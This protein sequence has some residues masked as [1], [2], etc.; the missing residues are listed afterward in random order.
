MLPEFSPNL[1]ISR[2][3][4]RFTMP[5]AKAQRSLSKFEEMRE[6]L[7]DPILRPEAQAWA[8]RHG[9]ELIQDE[10]GRAID[11]LPNQTFNH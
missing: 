9:Y 7:S 8:I 3:V 1:E 5:E 10:Y 11:M 6:W 2:L 4:Q